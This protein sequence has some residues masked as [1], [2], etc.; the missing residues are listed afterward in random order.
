MFSNLKIEKM[1]DRECEALM[2]KEENPQWQRVKNKVRFG[3]DSDGK[4]V[5]KNK[6]YQLRDG[7]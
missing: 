7:L 1:E 2:P 4:P 3:L 6:V 5:S